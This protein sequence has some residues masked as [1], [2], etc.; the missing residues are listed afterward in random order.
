MA[1]QGVEG[2]A[3]LALLLLLLDCRVDGDGIY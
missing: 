2:E 1:E 3:I